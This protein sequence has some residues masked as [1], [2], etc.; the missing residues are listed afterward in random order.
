MK[1]DLSVGRTV[2]S[3][4]GVFSSIRVRLRRWFMSPTCSGSAGKEYIG[5]NAQS[6]FGHEKASRRVN[7]NSSCSLS[8]W[9]HNWPISCHWYW[10]AADAMIVT[11]P[12]FESAVT[13]IQ[14]GNVRAFCWE[15]RRKMT[16]LEIKVPDQSHS[17]ANAT[18]CA[19]ITT[20]DKH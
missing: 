1:L 18:R 20:N 15:G 19:Y 5:H 14:L 11:S 3:A 4:E 8:L 2:L 17:T 12:L 16:E 10:S 7:N 13:K 9:C 6:R